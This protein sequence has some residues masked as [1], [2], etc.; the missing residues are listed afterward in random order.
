MDFWWPFPAP[1]RTLFCVRLWRLPIEST[2]EISHTRRYY[3]SYDFLCKGYF[4]LRLWWATTSACACNWWRTVWH[5]YDEKRN[6]LSLFRHAHNILTVS[7]TF[8][9]RL[10]LFFWDPW[11][12]CF[13]TNSISI[14]DIVNKVIVIGCYEFLFTYLKIQIWHQKF[15]YLFCT[16]FEHAYVMYIIYGTNSVT[17]RWSINYTR[18]TQYEGLIFLSICVP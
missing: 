11:L 13:T 4:V 17:N 12:H 3:S 15:N 18:S 5:N 7:K 14:R 8:P 2:W 9:W 6:A 10:L 1:F 16:C